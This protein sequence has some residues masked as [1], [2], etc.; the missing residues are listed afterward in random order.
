MPMIMAIENPRITAPPRKYST[1]TDSSVT[2]LVMMVRES[3]SLIERFMMS[4]VEPL[5]RLRKFSRMRSSTTTVSLT[6]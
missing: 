6:E 2:K 5:R 4:I 3:V 1:I